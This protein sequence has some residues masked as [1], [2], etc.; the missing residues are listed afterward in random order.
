M[1][2]IQGMVSDETYE[3]VKGIVDACNEGWSDG[4]VKTQDVLDWLLSEAKPDITKIR[5]RCLLPSK[6]VG[7][8][9][10]EFV[11]DLDFYMKKVGQLRSSLKSRKDS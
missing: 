2:R 3:K 10:I 6:V 11:E 7:S 4:I 9:K 5:T 8:V 1:K